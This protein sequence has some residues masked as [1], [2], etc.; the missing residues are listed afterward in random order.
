[1]NPVRIILAYFIRVSGI[2]TS[3]SYVPMSK[4]N[5]LKY[6]IHVNSFKHSQKK[7]M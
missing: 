6:N 2:L 3:A 5:K 4:V 1:M 7:K